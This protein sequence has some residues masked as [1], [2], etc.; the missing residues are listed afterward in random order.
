MTTYVESKQW[1]V[2]MRIFKVRGIKELVKLV[3]QAREA[4]LSP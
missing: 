3:Y 1:G 2:G 4:Y